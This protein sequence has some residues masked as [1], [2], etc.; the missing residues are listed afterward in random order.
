[1][2]KNALFET[3]IPSLFLDHSP[4]LTITDK[5]ANDLFSA[6]LDSLSHAK[7]RTVKSIP[8][9]AVE[10]RVPMILNLTPVRHRTHDLFSQAT[11]LLIVTPVNRARVP[12]AEVIQGLFDLTPA[13]ARVAR[14]IGQAQEG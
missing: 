6:A 4:R 1:M 13:E 11:A 3:L 10:G 12:T 9:A 7:I 8:I 5:A 2:A 14:G